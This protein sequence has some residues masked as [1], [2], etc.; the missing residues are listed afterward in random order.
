VCVFV[1][2]CV[3]V[4]VRVCVCGVWCECECEL[5]MR[6]V[7]LYIVLCCVVFGLVSASLQHCFQEQDLKRWSITQTVLSCL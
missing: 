1:Y 3:C 7:C 5:L 6:L 4:C 2:V